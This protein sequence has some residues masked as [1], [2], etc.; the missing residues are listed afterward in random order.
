VR[1]PDASANPYFAFTADDD[2]GAGWHPE[3][4]PSRGPGRQGSLRPRARGSES[5]FRPCAT[6]STWRSSTSTGIGSS[7]TRG[8]VFTNDVIDAYSGLK[9]Q[10]VTKFRM[11]THPVELELYYSC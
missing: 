11:S 1:F 9:L 10:E 7:S 4:D 3:Q 8:G 6:P 2:G 5:T